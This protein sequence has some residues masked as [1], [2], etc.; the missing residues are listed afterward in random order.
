M[1]SQHNH[2]L[3]T[4]TRDRRFHED[5]ISLQRTFKLAFQATVSFSSVACDLPVDSQILLREDHHL[6]LHFKQS[7][8]C[9]DDEAQWTS[10]VPECE[11]QSVSFSFWWKPLFATWEFRRLAPSDILSAVMHQS[12][13]ANAA[14]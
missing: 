8:S 2:T 14:E 3:A 7:K 12:G 11:S 1:A 13:I 4:L 9:D 6:L 10:A 5:R